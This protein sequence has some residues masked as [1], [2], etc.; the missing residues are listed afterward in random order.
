MK[1]A[2]S[3]PLEDKPLNEHRVIQK[4]HD[5]TQ[6]K[7]PHL[8][9]FNVPRDWFKTNSRHQ[10]RYSESGK[11]I[12]ECR[13]LLEKVVTANPQQAGN[14]ALSADSPYIHSYFNI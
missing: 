5:D 8:G 3:F 1:S 10:K 13:G 6:E 9:H 4:R 12:R 14:F 7:C 11:K 2:V